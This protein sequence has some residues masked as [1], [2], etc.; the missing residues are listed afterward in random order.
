MAEHTPGPWIA[1]LNRSSFGPNGRFTVCKDVTSG[2]RTLICE[3]P[4]AF[5]R[6]SQAAESEA[7][8]CL[9]AAAPEMLEALRLAAKE[10]NAI[11]ARDGAPQH[12]DWHRGQ[13]LQ[14][15]SCTEEWWDELT[16]KCFAAIAR[17]EGED[18]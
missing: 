6:R 7:N 18:E 5:A 3:M 15:S 9:I 17:V 1:E 10:L 13:P 14:T 12:I 16:D 4:H 11:R 2:E 8:A